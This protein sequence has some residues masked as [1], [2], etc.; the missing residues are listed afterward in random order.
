MILV[1]GVSTNGAKDLFPDS[2]SLF[3]GALIRHLDIQNMRN[4]API[5]DV[6]LDVIQQERLFSVHI[7][8]CHGESLYQC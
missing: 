4:I 1:M 7:Y 2:V 8:L 3:G 6:L 5:S